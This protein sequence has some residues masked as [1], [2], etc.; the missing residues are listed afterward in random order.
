MKG[1]SYGLGSNTDHTKI[2]S[3]DQGITREFR[4]APMAQDY[5]PII[6]LPSKR[7]HFFWTSIENRIT[8]QDTDDCYC[9]HEDNAPTVIKA[10]KLNTQI[11]QKLTISCAEIPWRPPRF[12]GLKKIT[13]KREGDEVARVTNS[14]RYAPNSS[15]NQHQQNLGDQSL[16]LVGVFPDDYGQ[17]PTSRLLQVD[18]LCC[19]RFKS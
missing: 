11:S 2:S 15:F 4:R 18:Q 13:L 16:V 14:V 1:L 7:Q 12:R 17:Y 8:V 10:L 9:L 6:E 3:A 19:G 5:G